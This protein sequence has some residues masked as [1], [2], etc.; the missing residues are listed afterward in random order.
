MGPNY[1]PKNIKNVRRDTV[2]F[3]FFYDVAPFYGALRAA[4][5]IK[6]RAGGALFR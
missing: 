4:W 1:A 6:K 5:A 3:L 2:T